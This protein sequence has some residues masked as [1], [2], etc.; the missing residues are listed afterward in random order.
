MN[1]WRKMTQDWVLVSSSH[2]KL[3]D[4]EEVWDCTR[5]C[6]EC[7]AV[8]R[9][10]SVP[11]AVAYIAAASPAFKRRR[12]DNDAFNAADRRAAEAFEGLSKGERRLI[13]IQDMKTV[14]APLT[15]F[16]ELKCKLF[17]ERSQKIE[18]QDALIAKL[19]SCTNMDEAMVLIPQLE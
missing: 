15:R 6:A 7:I 2:E 16:L 5:Y 3:D 10:I 18:E 11:E 19:R 8:Q 13:A 9:G 17:K 1:D 12:Q 4:P 14:L